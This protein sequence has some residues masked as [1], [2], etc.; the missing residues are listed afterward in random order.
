MRSLIQN[1]DHWINEMFRCR[2]VSDKILV[3]SRGVVFWSTTY[4]PVIKYAGCNFV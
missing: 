4:S 2:D 3:R 1:E